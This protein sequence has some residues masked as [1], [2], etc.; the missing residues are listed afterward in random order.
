MNSLESDSRSPRRLWSIPIILSNH[1]HTLDNLRPPWGSLPHNMAYSSAQTI[2]SRNN[3]PRFY[4]TQWPIVDPFSPFLEPQ[5]HYIIPT[6]LDNSPLEPTPYPFN[7]MPSPSAGSLSTG[8]TLP[9]PVLN[10]AYQFYNPHQKNIDT[11]NVLTRQL[12]VKHFQRQKMVQGL[13]IQ[14]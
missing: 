10:F 14:S 13:L 9:A 5:P 7:F 12:L 1:K 6:T 4:S 11:S 2:P 8:G 3:Q